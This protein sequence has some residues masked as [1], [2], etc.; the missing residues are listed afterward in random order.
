MGGEPSEKR[1]D[2]FGRRVDARKLAAQGGSAGKD[3]LPV[4]AGKRYAPGG[5][6]RRQLNRF[7]GGLPQHSAPFINR[8]NLIRDRHR[9]MRR[10]NEKLPIRGPMATAS[11]AGCVPAG[12]QRM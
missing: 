10:E 6:P 2:F 3:F 12:E 11:S 8:P 5:R 1:P 9:F 7:G 4:P